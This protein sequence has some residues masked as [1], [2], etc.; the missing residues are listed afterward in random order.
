MVLP[1]S[2]AGNYPYW[3]AKSAAGDLGRAIQQIELI[4]LALSDRIASMTRFYSN[5]RVRH[6]RIIAATWAEVPLLENRPRRS[7]A[8][9]IDARF[10]KGCQSTSV[11]RGQTAL[12]GIGCNHQG[13]RRVGP[14]TPQLLYH[15]VGHDHIASSKPIICLTSRSESP[16]RFLRSSIRFDPTK[17]S[18]SSS[19]SRT[20][21]C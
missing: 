15:S 11:E 4:G 12:Q 18:S 13:R 2:L 10:R 1:L 6:R 8:H 20:R 21:P 16:Q 3:N 5:T 7:H 14:L 17:R 19:G 9:V